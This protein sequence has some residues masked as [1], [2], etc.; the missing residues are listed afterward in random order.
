MKMDRYQEATTEFQKALSLEINNPEAI[1]K[2]MAINYDKLGF[3]ELSQRHEAL[4]QP[5]K[6]GN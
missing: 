4:S 6:E 5:A 2:K 3:K 1:H